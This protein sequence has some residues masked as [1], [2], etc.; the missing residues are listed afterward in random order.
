M[1]IPGL[2]GL[3]GELAFELP[4]DLDQDADGIPDFHQVT[5]AVSVSRGD[6]FFV[7]YDPVNVDATLDTGS[8]SVQWNR[9]AGESRGTC[10]VT[11]TGEQ[12]LT[13]PLAFNHAFEIAEYAGTYTYVPSDSPVLGNIEVIQVGNPDRRI[14]GPLVLELWSGEFSGDGAEILASVWP[15]ALGR[16]FTVE[17]GYLERA[18]EYPVEYFGEFLWSDNDVSTAERF[19]FGTVFIGIDDPNDQDTDGIPDLTDPPATAANPRLTLSR[20]GADLVLE[21]EGELN[22]NFQL[23]TAPALTTNPDWTQ[24]ASVTLT[25]SPQ[26]ILLPTPTAA[27][28]FWRLAVVP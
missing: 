16:E 27:T 8:V 20:A 15:N 2:S 24:V 3:F 18:S 4:L 6:G 23:L 10:V 28:A 1:T 14:E 7:I 17:T 25:N 13:A 12:F 22:R 9:N 5:N 19:G 11:L 26:T 21:I